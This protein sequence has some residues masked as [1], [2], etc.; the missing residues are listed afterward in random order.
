MIL[1]ETPINEIYTVIMDELEKVS[2]FANKN[3]K[4]VEKEIDEVEYRR[5]L[6]KILTYQVPASKNTYVVCYCSKKEYNTV[7]L[8]CM[9][10]LV[11]NE[12]TDRNYYSIKPGT[13]LIQVTSHFLKRYRERVLKN[14]TATTE[15]LLTIAAD[16]CLHF[17]ELDI[18]K[19]CPNPEKYKDNASA[20]VKDGIIFFE[21][22]TF[23]VPGKKD[24]LRFIKC[25][26]I[27]SRDMVKKNQKEEIKQK[28]FE[29]I[30]QF[31]NNK[32]NSNKSP[33]S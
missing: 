23:S 7:Q 18:D 21:K 27:V 14:E 33:K 17:I 20:A 16:R 2:F 9:F 1:P 6:I 29:E 19:I 8:S 28:T 22:S 4:S 13:G 30:Q 26:T 31:I 32:T 12:W 25:R 10:F 3:M 11:C 24:N 15:E 5:N